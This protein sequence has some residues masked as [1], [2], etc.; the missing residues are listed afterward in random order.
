MVVGQDGAHHAEPKLAGSAGERGDEQVRGRRER[1]GEVV[2]AE[3][4]ALEAER[5]VFGPETQISFEVAPTSDAGAA[6]PAR[7]SSGKNSNNQGLIT[8]RASR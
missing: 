6:P 2:L 8:K 7:V 4:D 3:E 1:P 5:F